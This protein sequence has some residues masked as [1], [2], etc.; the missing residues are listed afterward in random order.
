MA[1]GLSAGKLGVDLNVSYEQLIKRY[2]WAFITRFGFRITPLPT[3]K[4][5]P[6]ASSFKLGI[7]NTRSFVSVAHYTLDFQGE[8]MIFS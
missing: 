2:V 8:F 6:L 3:R 4:N 5:A 7:F 1:N